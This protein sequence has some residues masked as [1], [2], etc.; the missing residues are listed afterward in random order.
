MWHVDVKF[1]KGLT[2]RGAHIAAFLYSCRMV[3]DLRE[4]YHQDHQTVIYDSRGVQFAICER[5]HDPVVPLL[6]CDDPASASTESVLEVQI[7]VFVIVF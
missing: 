7:F 4:S 6:C 5:I 1:T 2:L 3:L